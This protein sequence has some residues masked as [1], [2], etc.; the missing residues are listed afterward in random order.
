MDTSLLLIITL[1]PS[2]IS[3]TLPLLVVGEGWLEGSTEKKPV[4]WKQEEMRPEQVTHV[5]HS[6]LKELEGIQ[7]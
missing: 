7:I 6:R 5:M 2:S 3:L 1:V 4:P